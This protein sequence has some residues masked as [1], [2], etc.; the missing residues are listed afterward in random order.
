MKRLISF[1][2]I[3]SVVLVWLFLQM[4]AHPASTRSTGSPNG[5]GNTG[6][7]GDG[8]TCAQSGCHDD[9]NPKF[10]SSVGSI[11]TNIPASGYVPGQTYTVTASVAVAGKNT[12]GFEITS[13][14][15]MGT[16]VGSWSS[17]SGETQTTNN[18]DAMTH[19]SSGISGSGSKS[20]SMDWQAPSSG[21]GPVE[22]QAAFNVAD[23]N[24]FASGDTIHLENISVDEDSSATAFPASN[25]QESSGFSLHPI[26]AKD[27]LNIR[28]I[29][30]DEEEGE[31]L[32]RDLQGRKL[33]TL[34]SGKLSAASNKPLSLKRDLESGAYLI[35]LRKEEAQVFE[36]ILIE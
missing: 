29:E 1:L 31:I 35:E 20:W 21:T 30:D 18:G 23:G 22:F 17:T 10:P 9:D 26:P 33:Q 28:G 19:T 16:K 4:G 12:F 15:N 2:S 14:A 5:G 27:H 32:L 7:T 3:F 6:S 13:E 8:I 34:Y 24:S 25:V 11:S 36:K